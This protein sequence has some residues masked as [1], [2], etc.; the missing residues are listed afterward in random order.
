MRKTRLWIGIVL[1]L[2]TLPAA[3]GCGRRD[4]TRVVFTTGFGKDEV[5]RIEDESCR[6][7]EIMVYLTTIQNQY[8]SVY[9]EEIWNTELDGVTL[10][11][12][13]KETVLAR[14]A[15]V[16]TMYLLALDKGVELDESEIRQVDRA[17][18]EYWDSLNET[19]IEKMGV[20]PETITGLYTEYALAEKVYEFL[21]EGINPE[22]SDDEARTIS[23]QHILLRTYTMD[24]AGKRVD[25]SEG[26]RQATYEK[27]CEI[28]EMAASGE[29]DFTELASRYSEDTNITYSFGKGEMEEHFEAAAF[30]LE[31]DEISPVVESDSGYHIIKC[32][33]T[34]DRQET[35]ANK[36]KIVEQRCREAFGQEYDA[37]VETLAKNLNRSLWEE[38][39]LIHDE[40]VRTDNF[41]VIYDKYFGDEG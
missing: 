40:E 14:I 27:A 16:K 34:F 39:E 4:G 20:S 9:G 23:V 6:V 5:F 8:E 24:G 41:F 10:E 18:E 25:Y 29:Y 28:R 11:E 26:A 12:N 15:Q 32:I 21:I 36:L 3:V 33:N 1:L 2:L 22:I 13:V 17:A 31:T 37:F 35:D 7:D 19:E 38:I 30:L